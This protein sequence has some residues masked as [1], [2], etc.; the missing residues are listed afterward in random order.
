[1]DLVATL[2]RVVRTSAEIAT[3]IRQ[4]RERLDPAGVRHK[5]PGDV[6]TDIDLEAEQWLRGRL[7]QVLPG[8]AFLGEESGGALTE[9]PTWIVDPIDGTANYVRGYPQYA[10]SVALAID[11]EPVLGVIA[12]PCRGEVFAA[13]R[14]AGAMLNGQPLRCASRGDPL[15]CIAATVFPK[16]RAPFMDGYL[17]EFGRVIRCFGQVRRSGSMALE[18]AYLAA[19][20]IDA[21]WERG[22][23]A[24]DAAAGIVLL[25]ESG[26]RI[27]AR[28][29]RP[30]LDSQFLCAA[31]PAIEAAWQHCLQPGR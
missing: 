18:L 28:D 17:D 12:D 1:M 14:G 3:Q 29:G 22:M 4:Q 25:Q 21:F 5:A 6:A 19:G 27:A 24:W 15:Q 31:T 23:G 11:R 10:V 13:A 26:A 2:D 30:L 8:S 20:R 9:A 7:L 16:P